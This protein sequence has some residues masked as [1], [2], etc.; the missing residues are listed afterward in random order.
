MAAQ[1]P[2]AAISGIWSEVQHL[3]LHNPQL[4]PKMDAMRDLAFGSVA[5]STQQR[6]VGVYRAFTTFCVTNAVPKP[7]MPAAPAKIGLFLHHLVEA[8]AAPPTMS[9]AVAALGWAHA[10]S[11]HRNPFAEDPTLRMIAAG[12]RRANA[13]QPHQFAHMSLEDYSTL[14][15][16]AVTEG[17]PKAVQFAFMLTC[18]FHAATR[19]Q[20]LRGLRW[21]DVELRPAGVMLHVFR[22]K[23][24]LNGERDPCPL[25]ATDEVTCPMRIAAT[26]ASLFDVVLPSTS[27]ATLWPAIPAPGKEIDWSRPLSDD[28]FYAL[29]RGRVAAIGLNPNEYS[30]HSLRSG[31]ATAAD[32]QGLPEHVIATIGGWAGPSSMRRYMRVTEARRTQAT[33]AM[34]EARPPQ[35][36]AVQPAAASRLTAPAQ[37][38]ATLRSTAPAQPQGRARGTATAPPRA[39]RVPERAS[40]KRRGRVPHESRLSPPPQPNTAYATSGTRVRPPLVPMEPVGTDPD[41]AGGSSVEDGD[42]TVV[43]S[44][45]Q[46]EHDASVRLGSGGGRFRPPPAPSTTMYRRSLSSAFP[47]SRAPTAQHRFGSL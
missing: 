37:P 46:A 41:R 7:Y 17:T 26:Y 40:R 14:V 39:D 27:D 28:A 18:A 13:R 21:R 2:A 22:T 42:D 25:P 45:S 10:V 6:Y 11:G 33:A 1:L 29:L 43:L 44:A 47:S 5:P 12:G 32:E 30:W 36:P 3:A 24:A 8:D 4:Q 19:I 38:A 23:T 9:I 20:E 34:M 31:A 35:Q 15:L 16:L